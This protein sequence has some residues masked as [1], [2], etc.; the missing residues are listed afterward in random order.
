MNDDF[1]EEEQPEVYQPPFPIE[2]GNLP[3]LSRGS[4]GAHVRLL[5][6]FLNAWAF[7]TK[8]L[9]VSGIFN[10]RTEEAVIQFQKACK[11]LDNGAVGPNT[12]VKLLPDASSAEERLARIKSFCYIWHGRFRG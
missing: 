8:P 2:I 10:Q 11:L 12:W 4:M 9:I 7:N 6:Y 3:V 1:P 5:Q